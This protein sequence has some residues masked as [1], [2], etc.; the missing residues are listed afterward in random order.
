METALIMV[1]AVIWPSTGSAATHRRWA[2]GAGR[3]VPTD[4][5]APAA[6][7]V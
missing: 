2:L 6:D 1:D 5:V 3:W 7:P 4:R